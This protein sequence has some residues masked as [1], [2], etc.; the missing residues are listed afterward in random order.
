MYRLNRIYKYHT[1][2]CLCGI[3]VII[4]ELEQRYKIG[5]SMD[6]CQKLKKSPNFFQYIKSKVDIYNFAFLLILL[7]KCFYFILWY[8]ILRP[9]SL[10]IISNI[11]VSVT[12][13]LEKN[14]QR[15]QTYNW[16]IFCPPT[17]K[18]VSGQK[19]NHWCE[20]EYFLF[21]NNDSQY[22]KINI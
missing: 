8:I 18:W 7:P 20:P 14:I 19:C 16:H 13:T 17:H 10:N 1:L 11:L 9:F 3:L 22:K 21:I 4:I 2:F 6:F 5:Y 15:W 12:T